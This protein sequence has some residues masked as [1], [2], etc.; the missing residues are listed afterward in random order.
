MVEAW[1]RDEIDYLKRLS[2]FR[3]SI[4]VP[5]GGVNIRSMVNR[6][7]N[8]PLLSWAAMQLFS[9]Q[10]LCTKEGQR[11]GDGY[12]L[13]QG[14]P[15]LFRASS[16][17]IIHRGFLREGWGRGALV[18]SHRDSVTRSVSQEVY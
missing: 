6:V 17:G 15:D 7:P 18:K 10:G 13:R 4:T 8:R 2:P 12:L 1:P 3:T 9:M 5:I 11:K 14:P 16:D